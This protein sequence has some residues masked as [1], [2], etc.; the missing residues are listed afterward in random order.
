V[1]S[2]SRRHRREQEAIE[3]K[4]M[5]VAAQL[6]PWQRRIVAWAGMPKWF[7]LQSP[8]RPLPGRQEVAARG[9]CS[10]DYGLLE[11]DPCADSTYRLTPLGELV[12]GVWVLSAI[13]LP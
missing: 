2:I 1:S 13:T 10:A 8:W 5:R 6:T 7:C 3:S 9:L 11:R 4:A 12:A